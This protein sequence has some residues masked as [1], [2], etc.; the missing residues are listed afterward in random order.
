MNSV[1]PGISFSPRAYAFS[2]LILITIGIF[3]RIINFPAIPPG[4]NQDEASS[5]YEAFC[6]AETGKD[7]WGN[8]LPAY[9]PAWGSGQNVL[10]SYLSAPIVK[11]FGLSI[12]SS[13]LVSLILGILTLPL[14]YFC[15]RPLG[16]FPAFLGLLLIVV[17]P[18][19]F[20]L[21]RWALESN[22][23][24]FFMLL[25]CF[26]LIRAF[27]ANGS[28]W[29][30][31]SLIPFALALYGYGTTIVVLPTLFTLLLLFF[32]E[33]IRLQWKRWLAAFS[34][35]ILAALPF[36][37]FF[38][39]N[40]LLK[41]NLTWTDSLFFS[42]PLLP[43]SRLGQVEAA[44]WKETAL[45][46]LRFF[47]GG[48]DD[49]S[50]YNLIPGFKLLLFF[51]VPAS[52]IGIVAAGIR[53]FPSI[54]T[55]KPDKENSVVFIFFSWAIASLALIFSFE[56]NVN[57]FNHFYLPGLALVAWFVNLI[58]TN[59]KDTAPK[60]TIKLLL[61]TWL[62]LES[63]ITIRYYFKEY[64]KE[65]IR[66]HFNIGLGEAFA[67]ARNLPVDQV[68]ITDQ[69]PLP[70]V[71][72]LFYLQ[73][74]PK[75]FQTEAAYEIRDGVYKVNRFGKYIFYDEFLKPGKE[76]GYLS[77]KDEYQANENRTKEIIF[78]NELWE[79]GIIHYK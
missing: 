34:L 54:K 33:R 76:Y 74:P 43:S 79:V 32:R 44:D 55:N 31:P 50:N 22:L 20:M 7:R 68:R 37:L 52:V 70:Y 6:L 3:I 1:F 65:S 63:S 67:A 29:I 28:K 38:I 62:I 24:P 57:R 16:R 72:T 73:I 14:F 17:I 12:F 75:Q 13:R 71:Y 4:F 59:L 47:M 11:I 39:E 49:G 51:T 21:S 10:L 46:N 48:F 41:K 45:H 36:L 56:L 19:H 61:L 42:T 2:V 35:F 23:A 5:A 77:R 8:V 58:L 64:P 78:S 25:G 9:F 15:L 53:S 40:Y 30:L 18:W 26:F 60:T 69:M 27:A 66:H